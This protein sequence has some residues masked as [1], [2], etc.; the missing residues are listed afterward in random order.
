MHGLWISE[1]VYISTQGSSLQLPQNCLVCLWC[2]WFFKKWWL[3]RIYHT[4]R[5]LLL[6]IRYFIKKKTFWKLKQRSLVVCL[7]NCETFAYYIFVYCTY[8]WKPYVFYK[9]L[10]YVADLFPFTQKWYS[11]RQA[12]RRPLW[13]QWRTP[14]QRH[15]HSQGSLSIL[16]SVQLE[17][18][19]CIWDGYVWFYKLFRTCVFSVFD[20]K[21]HLSVQLWYFYCILDGYVLLCGFMIFLFV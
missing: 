18:L 20:D 21:F 7:F 17:I 6:I 2:K 9:A 4:P 10:I 8:V 19:Y 12:P 13:R 11:V 14:H 1:Q 3:K 5:S 16:M 15:R